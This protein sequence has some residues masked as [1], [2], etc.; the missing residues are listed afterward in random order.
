MGPLQLESPSTSMWSLSL[1][2][3]YLHW[4]LLLL[5]VQEK[6]LQALM[7]GNLQLPPPHVLPFAAALSAAGGIGGYPGGLGTLP[8]P[9][10][11]HPPPPPP[12]HGLGPP[13]PSL[14]P[15]QAPSAPS[16]RAVPL[17]PLSSATYH[18]GFQQNMTSS[19]HAPADCVNTD[20]QRSHSHR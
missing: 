6:F 14:G 13:P 11:P 7:S 3:W 19:S 18:P 9:V 8:Y 10:F 2:S 20:G 4:L 15:L 5:S 1:L 17:P 16:S 12:P